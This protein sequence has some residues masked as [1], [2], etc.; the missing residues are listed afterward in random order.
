MEEAREWLWRIASE[1]R[2]VTSG[3]PQGSVLGPLLFAINSNDVVNWISKF[4]DDT[5][6][7]DVLD[8]EEGFQS[9]QRYLDQLEKWQMEFNTEVRYCTLEGQTKVECTG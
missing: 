7:G 8:S 2:P 6:I 1:W 4:A 5:K 9:L 3:I